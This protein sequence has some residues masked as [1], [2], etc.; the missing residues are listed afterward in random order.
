MKAHVSMDDQEY[1]PYPIVQLRNK[2]PKRNLAGSDLLCNE[3]NS[4]TKKQSGMTAAQGLG[5]DLGE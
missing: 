4:R 1:A 2:V 3:E 5:Q